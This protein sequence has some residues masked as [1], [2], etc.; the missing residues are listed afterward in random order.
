MSL[1]TETSYKAIPVDECAKE[2]KVRYL[3]GNWRGKWGSYMGRK[4]ACLLVEA[5]PAVVRL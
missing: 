5:C 4:T 3:S 2:H 1:R